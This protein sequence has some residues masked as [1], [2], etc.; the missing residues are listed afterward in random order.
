[1][2]LSALFEIIASRSVNWPE[3][4]QRLSYYDMITSMW[5]FSAKFYNMRDA[6]QINDDIMQVLQGPCNVK[7]VLKIAHLAY[8]TNTNIEYNMITRR[9]QEVNICSI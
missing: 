2:R 9:D 5:Q 6:G 3:L 8:E 4:A 7:N 1:M